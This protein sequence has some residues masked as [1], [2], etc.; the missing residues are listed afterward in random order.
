MTN[1]STSPAAPYDRQA[2]IGIAITR[3]DQGQGGDQLDPRVQPVE[4]A[5]AVPM[6]LQPVRPHRAWP[7]RASGCGRTRAMPQL[8]PKTTSVPTTPAIA[9]ATPA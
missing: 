8:R 7:L 5:R 3:E 6:P 2:P 1:A 4:R 9:V